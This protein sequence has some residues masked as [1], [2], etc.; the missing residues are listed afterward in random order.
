MWRCGMIVLLG[1]SLLIGASEPSASSDGQGLEIAPSSAFAKSLPL[2]EVR[3]RE[4]AGCWRTRRRRN[5]S[6]RRLWRRLGKDKTKAAELLV[7]FFGEATRAH[8]WAQS[9]CSMH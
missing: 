7:P 2:D 8:A 4:R 3:V 9:G 6:A 1:S 5:A